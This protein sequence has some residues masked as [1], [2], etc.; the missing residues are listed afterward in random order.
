MDVK[1]LC[2]MAPWEWPDDAGETFLKVLRD[3]SA[4]ATDRLAAAAAAG[5]YIVMN[6]ELSDALLAIVRDA[7][8]SDELRCRAAI[9]FG[10]ALESADIFGFEDPEEVPISKEKFHEIQDCLR[11][12]VASEDVPVTVRRRILEGSIRSPAEWHR[13]LVHRAYASDDRDWR[14]TAV[15][16]MRFISGFDEQIVESVEDPDDAI[17]YEAIVAAGNWEVDGAWPRVEAVLA[18]P[19]ADKALLLAAVESAVSIRPDEAEMALLPLVDAEDQDIVD[20][21]HEALAMIECV[22][23][24]D[25]QDW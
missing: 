6:D 1:V 14:L 5:D 17:C 12:L 2:A 21:V 24:D 11:S 4:S 23:E 13:D 7:N 10:P 8:E 9:S 16:C 20:A 22:Q 15:F 25:G 19:N 18:S 3:G